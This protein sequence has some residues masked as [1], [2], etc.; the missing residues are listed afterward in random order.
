MSSSKQ[1]TILP[2]I[3][4]LKFE[5]YKELLRSL[6]NPQS[7]TVKFR[8]EHYM[9][10]FNRITRAIEVFTLDSETRHYLIEYVEHILTDLEALVRAPEPDSLAKKLVMLRIVKKVEPER[11][12]L[13]HG[14]NKYISIYEVKAP[15]IVYIEKKYPDFHNK[16]YFFLF[17]NYIDTF[18]ED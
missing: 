18:A 10:G 16:E 17:K 1:K 15:A 9:I 6:K 11:K 8:E 5:D 2:A 12:C 4:F 3:L 7:I 14:Y 13:I